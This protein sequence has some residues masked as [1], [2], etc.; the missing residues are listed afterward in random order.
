MSYFLFFS[1]IFDFKV[2]PQTLIR[3]REQYQK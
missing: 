2:K 3:K 1:E